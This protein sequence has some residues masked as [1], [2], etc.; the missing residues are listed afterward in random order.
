MSDN[1]SNSGRSIIVIVLL[2]IGL[3]LGVGPFKNLR[4]GNGNET[5][6]SSDSSVNNYTENVS[7]TGKY[8]DAEISKSKENVNS[9]TYNVETLIREVHHQ[10]NL[11]SLSDTQTGHENGSYDYEVKRLNDI[12]GKYNDAVDELEEAKSKLSEV[13]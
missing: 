11:V 9:C 10:E 2:L 8:S 13:Q 12:K 5:N 7:F 6:N 4:C 1:S 3:V